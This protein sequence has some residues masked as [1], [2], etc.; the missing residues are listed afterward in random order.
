MNK[1]E[2]RGR[3]S[4]VR[5]ALLLSLLAALV[6]SVVLIPQTFAATVTPS[7]YSTPGI[8]SAINSANAGDTINLSGA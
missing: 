4:G 3:V 6:M 8:Q 7:S 1:L 2:S 5:V